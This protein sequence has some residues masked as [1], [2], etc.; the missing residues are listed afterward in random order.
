M[1]DAAI[2]YRADELLAD[3]RNRAPNL[4]KHSGMRH[5]YAINKRITA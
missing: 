5:P 4:P 2:Q 3:A 1:T